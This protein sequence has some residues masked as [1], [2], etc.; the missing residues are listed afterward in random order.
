MEQLTN[1]LVQCV[2]LGQQSQQLELI[3]LR[4][5]LV[6]VL[7]P[8]YVLL[9]LLVIRVLVVSTLQLPALLIHFVLLDHPLQ[10]LA[11]T[12]LRS[13]LLCQHL[14]LPVSIL[15][16]LMEQLITQPV[17][18]VPLDQPSLQLTVLRVLLDLAL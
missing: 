4:V 3:V 9:V 5:L 18:P 12:Q 8:Q 17:Q 16:V 6:A 13:L 1:L 2:S 15:T 14:H 10:Y 11:K 7:P